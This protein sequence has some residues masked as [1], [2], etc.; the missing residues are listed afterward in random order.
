[1]AAA[2]GTNMFGRNRLVFLHAKNHF[3][4]EI[5]HLQQKEHGADRPR[6]CSPGICLGHFIR[7]LSVSPSPGAQR[8]LCL[9]KAQWLRS[10]WLSV[11]DTHINTSLLLAMQDKESLYNRLRQIDAQESALLKE[12]RAIVDQLATADAVSTSSKK[13]RLTEEE[14]ARILNRRAKVEQKRTYA[15]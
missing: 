13:Q 15:S 11:S 10:R 3:L 12:R 14:K 6:L 9:E 1:M 7:Q 5:H 4:Y 2:N 8:L